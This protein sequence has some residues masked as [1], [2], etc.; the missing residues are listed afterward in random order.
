MSPI[1]PPRTPLLQHVIS[2]INKLSEQ[3]NVAMQQAAFI[4]M[5]EEEVSQKRVLKESWTGGVV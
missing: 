2:E 4:G 5:T 3:Q 1:Q